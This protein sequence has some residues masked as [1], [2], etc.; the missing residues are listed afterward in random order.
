M[1]K[2]ELYEAIILWVKHYPKK[3]FSVFRPQTF[4]IIDNVEDFNAPNLNRTPGDIGKPFFWNRKFV[5]GKMP[6]L[7][8]PAI[9]LIEL[10]SKIEK[11]GMGFRRK[12]AYDL[13]CIIDHQ[14]ACTECNFNLVK[15]DLH[16]LSERFLCELILYI[17]SL[18]KYEIN[19]TSVYL[20]NALTT[21]L[22]NDK[23]GDEE[24][25]PEF[26]LKNT[27][28]ALIDK[29]IEIEGGNYR[30]INLNLYGYVYRLTLNVQDCLNVYEG[31]PN[32]LNQLYHGGC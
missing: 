28:L 10:Q 31:A 5:N 7:V 18:Q 25:E 22:Y 17:D 8:T 16:Q 13:I 4:S 23:L 19:G 2:S 29:S 9:V 12:V 27:T 26:V 32:N 14:K 30:N 21:L 6:E 11:I 3:D 15:E 20:S 24:N 1:T